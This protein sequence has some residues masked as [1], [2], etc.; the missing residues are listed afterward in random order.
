MS[1]GSGTGL[2]TR[3]SILPVPNIPQ[4]PGV[5][6]PDYS[7]ADNIK[8]P[9][10][11]GVRD[12]SSM[13]SVVDAVKGVGYYVDTIGFGESSSPL[14]RGM[15]LKPLGVN[16]WMKT[17]LT[18]S[19][20]AEMYQYVEGIP[21]GDALGQRVADGLRSAGMPGM[22]GLAPGIVEDAKAAL[23]P[24]PVLQAVFGSGYPS[25]R[26][27][28]RPVGDQ[29][30]RIRNPSTGKSYVENPETVVNGQQ[31]RWVYA[32]SL[33][34]D[35]WDKTPKTHCPS[36]YPRKN[37]RDMNCNDRLESLQEGFTEDSRKTAILLGIALAGSLVLLKV[38]HKKN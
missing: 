32:G 6:G 2:E 13:G 19:N 5:F 23:N 27:E 26:F 21:R 37:Y 1:S 8:L 30:G 11:V 4:G 35:Q 31:G 7:F 18:C 28:R 38:F 24:T 12:G 9:G 22:R 25:C 16:F 29:D 15:G 36:G 34:K 3:T 20:G 33:T 14:T 17:G 10:E